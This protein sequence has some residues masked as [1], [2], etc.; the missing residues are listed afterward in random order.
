MTIRTKQRGISRR[1]WRL[2]TFVLLVGLIASTVKVH[3]SARILT[4]QMPA[5][6]QPYLQPVLAQLATDSTAWQIQPLDE[7]TGQPN[8][9]IRAGMSAAANGCRFRYVI[10]AAVVA[11]DSDIA[12]VSD[13]FAEAS[14][15]SDEV[16]ALAPNA[17]PNASAVTMTH[18][19]VL[20]AVL[21]D[22]TKIGV[23]RWQTG[24]VWPHGIRPLRLNGAFPGETESVQEFASVMIARVTSDED[25]QRL[26]AALEAWS[27]AP[28]QIAATG[29]IMLGRTIDTLAVNNNNPDYPFEKIAPLLASADLRIGNLECVISELGTAQYKAYAF[30]VGYWGIEALKNANFDLLTM[31]NNHAL[32]FGPAA[33][34]DTR[35]RLNAAGIPTVGAGKNEAQARSPVILERNGLRIAF[36]GY[37]N[38]PRERYGFD[39]STTRATADSAGVAWG[40]PDMIAADVRAA[41]AQAD[42]VVVMLHSGLEWRIEPNDMQRAL[43]KAAIEAGAVAVIGAHP[44]VMQGIEYT[45][46]ELPGVIAYSLGNFVFEANDN[47]QAFLR[48]W[49]AA[50]GVRAYAWEPYRVT[51]S[52][53]PIPANKIETHLILEGMNSMTKTLND[54]RQIE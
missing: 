12:D 5:T 3:A 49:V 47:G 15:V 17:V 16:Q 13:G 21:A 9:V 36:L 35:E 41:K 52:G 4:V 18:D 37:A 26:C 30:R 27:A 32:D 20:Q 24:G 25:T 14:L 54:Q 8:Y 28:I 29:D 33:M 10:P 34:L 46:Q 23:V 38:T 53:R 11:V 6:W 39:P 51:L 42:L 43:A 31:G 45:D 7:A 19:E 44:H 1:L 22:K 48:L 50:G 40:E 2:M